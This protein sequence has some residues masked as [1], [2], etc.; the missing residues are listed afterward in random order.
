MPSAIVENLIELQP[1]VREVVLTPVLDTNAYAAL[2]ALHTANLQF[3]G[4]AREAGGAG[5]ITKLVIIDKDDQGAAG[6]L[7]LFTAATTQTANSAFAPTD[8]QAGTYVGS[9]AFGAFQDFNTSR[10]STNAAERLYYKCA[11][12]STSLF[13]VL[14]TLGTPTHTPSGLDVKLMAELA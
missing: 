7:H 3:T 11:A 8:D 13:G 2:D 6:V 5:V 4:L 10:V 1:D 9:I 12:G 14:Q